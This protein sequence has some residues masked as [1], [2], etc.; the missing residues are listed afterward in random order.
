MF[1]QSFFAIKQYHAKSHILS[2]S[3]IAIPKN[4]VGMEMFSR[5]I[6]ASKKNNVKDWNLVWIILSDSDKTGQDRKI[7]TNTPCD[8]EISDPEKMSTHDHSLLFRII[9]RSLEAFNDHSLRLKKCTPCWNFFHDQFLQ[10]GNT[11]SWW[12]SCHDQSLHFRKTCED[13]ILSTI[14]FCD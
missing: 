8:R 2:W 7:F 5:S 14:I 9:T 1:S 10:L 6:N 4:N 3:F 11:T 13:G 12:S